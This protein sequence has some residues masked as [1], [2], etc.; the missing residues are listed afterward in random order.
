[1]LTVTEIKGAVSEVID[2]YPIKKI[3]LFGSYAEG[4]A[5]EDSDVDML[6]EFFSPY[7][8]LFMIHSIKEEIESKLSKNI[9]LIHAPLDE[10]SFIKI[11]K[12]IDIYEL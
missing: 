12:V 11:D 10:K 8:S 3:S 1:M 5:T 4:S 6:V 2:K 9:D 7:V